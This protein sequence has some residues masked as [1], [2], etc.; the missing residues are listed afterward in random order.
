MNNYDMEANSRIENLI[1][2]KKSY[3]Y[4]IKLIY[5]IIEKFCPD[6]SDTDVKNFTFIFFQSDFGFWC[7]MK[8]KIPDYIIFR[9]PFAFF[10]YN[11]SNLLVFFENF[12]ILIFFAS[13][14]TTIAILLKPRIMTTG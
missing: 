1:E 5:M 4:S 14:G 7:F 8:S 13:M 6:M 3:G 11:K 9:T 12:S 10:D 2:F